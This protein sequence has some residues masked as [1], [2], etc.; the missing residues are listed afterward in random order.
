[1]QGS[2]LDS[3]L[4]CFVARKKSQVQ[5]DRTMGGYP[6]R[7]EAVERFPTQAGTQGVEQ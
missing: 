2:V 5:E 1:M 3:P 6:R 4:R 7:A